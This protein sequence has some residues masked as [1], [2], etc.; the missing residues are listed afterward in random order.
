MINGCDNLQE[1]SDGLSVTVGIAAAAGL[2]LL[3]FSEV[4]FLSPFSTVPLIIYIHTHLETTQIVGLPYLLQI[5]TILQLL[6]SAAIVQ[7]V[8]KKFLYAEVSLHFMLNWI[9]KCPKILS[10]V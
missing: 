9:I 5:E 7:L 2:G 3:A 4:R 8:S 6:G 1:G 10:S